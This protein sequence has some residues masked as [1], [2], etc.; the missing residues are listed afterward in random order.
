M[1]PP[2]LN[3]PRPRPENPEFPFAGHLHYQGEDI[4]VETPAGRVRSGTGPDGKPWA[5]R[6]PLHYGEVRG[7]VGADGDAVDVFV[8]PS[9]FS[10]WAFVV[11][12]KD[13]TTGKF[14]ETKTVLGVDTKREAMRLVRMAYHRR[15]MVMGVT[16]WPIGSWKAGI[17]RPHVSVGTMSRPLAKAVP[18]D[19]VRC[20]L[21]V[22]KLDELYKATVKQHFR[23]GKNGPVLV[24]QFDRKDRPRAN[25]PEPDE[26]KPFFTPEEQNLPKTARQPG[27]DVDELMQHAHE[28]HQ[29][30]V[31]LVNE[32]QGIDSD[33]GAKV[34]RLDKLGSDE[35]EKAM[36]DALDKPGPVVIV[37]PMKS[38]SRIE[39]KV[40]AD[41]GGD[42]TQVLD[43]SRSTIAVDTMDQLKDVLGH[44]R[45][46]GI[47]LARAPKDKFTNPAPGG[48]RDLN[49]NLRMPNGH[50][51][52]VQVHVKPMLKA[53]AHAHDDYEEIQK[54]D[55]KV[56]SEGRV[57]TPEER[58]Q[59]AHHMAK[60]TASYS[61]AWAQANG[62]T[63]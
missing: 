5:V 10:P 40:N 41:Y 61:A 48:Y 37:G 62:G 18:H 1:I 56:L 20:V 45:A 4:D 2:P 24:R 16:R 19:R 27:K 31:K 36:Q 38:R 17:R 44:L 15:G 42:H 58:E 6:M 30:H 59:V 46:R 51:V 33:I 25:R 50:A 54:I 9:A 57:H 8:G 29:H 35:R 39:A 12:I 55:R 3:P 53:K 43:M 7:T 52:E 49:M 23:R 34:V 14:D 13:P 47:T 60:L 11:Q 22:R 28:A 21:D 26:H 63:P 32:G